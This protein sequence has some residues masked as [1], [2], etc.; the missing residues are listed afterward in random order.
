MGILVGSVDQEDQVAGQEDQ[1][2]VEDRQEDL[3]EALEEQ[4]ASDEDQEDQDQEEVG[5]RE[6][7]PRKKVEAVGFLELRK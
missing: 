1:G 2:R 5:E 6:Q 4:T 7:E 3:L